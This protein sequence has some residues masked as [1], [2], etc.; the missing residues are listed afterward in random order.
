M[1]NQFAYLSGPFIKQFLGAQLLPKAVAV[2]FQ[3]LPFYMVFP[4]FTKHI[5]NTAHVSGKLSVNL[6]KSAQTVLYYAFTQ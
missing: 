2:S 4:S 1:Q 5:L 3:P 6:I